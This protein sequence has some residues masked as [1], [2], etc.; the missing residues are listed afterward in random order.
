MTLADGGFNRSMQQLDGIVRPVYRSLVSAWTFVDPSGAK[1]LVR[2]ITV[3]H[4]GMSPETLSPNVNQT[5]FLW[6]RI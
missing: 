1:R 3:I 4:L 6:G 5:H 2:E